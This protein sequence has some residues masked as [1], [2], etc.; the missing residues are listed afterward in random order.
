MVNERQDSLRN[1][2]KA[3][4]DMDTRVTA[5]PLASR[6]YGAVNWM[7]LETLIRREIQRFLKVGAQTVFAPLIQ[8]LLFMMVFS[9]VRQG[10]WPGTTRAYADGLAAGLVM[11]SILSNAFQ[12]SSSSLVIAKVQGNAVDF[13]MPPLSALELT[14]AFIVGAAARGLLVGA[15]SLI[16]VAW[17]AN[18]MPVNIFVALYYAIVASVIFG[19]I[20]LIGGIWAD[21]FDH[22]AAVTN[23]IIVPLTFLSGTFYSTSILPEPIRTISHYNP[24]FS[25]IDGFRYGFIGHHDA[26]LL[27]GALITGG[28]ALALSYASW[29]MIKSGYRLR[30]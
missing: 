2:E 18:I 12:N 15:A 8:T 13:L 27:T 25:L 11:M 28:L 30:S 5:A 14:I 4:P 29:A 24:V 1:Y 16:A 7:G 23:F 22:L 3:V 20:G 9:L 21:K 19:A 26:P 6:H 10:D 17:L